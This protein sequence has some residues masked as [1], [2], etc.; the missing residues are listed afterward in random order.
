MSNR[1]TR[2]AFSVPVIIAHSTVSVAPMP[3]HTA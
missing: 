2:P 1:R 3:T